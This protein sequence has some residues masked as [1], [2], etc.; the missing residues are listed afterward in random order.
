MI[1]SCTA[2][3]S[4]DE[5]RLG[6]V[7]PIFSSL[8][9]NQQFF[10]D[11]DLNGII[12]R[13]VPSVDVPLHYIQILPPALSAKVGD[14]GLLGFVDDLGN[15]D[16]AIA[17]ELDIILRSKEISSPFT[18]LE[19]AAF[20]KNRSKQ[21]IA[22]ADAKKILGTSKRT[23]EWADREKKTFQSVIDMGA[24]VTA[25]PDTKNN[26][27]KRTLRN[28]ELDFG[29][30]EW[31]DN[32]FRLWGQNF[33]RKK[34]IG[35]ANLRFDTIGYNN[36]HALDIFLLISQSR[37]PERDLDR[38][39]K[40]IEASDF[41]E[42]KWG[43]A[44]DRVYWQL[45]LR[46]S[47]ILEIGYKKIVETQNPQ[48]VER[49]WIRV[50]SLIFRSRKY[51]PEILKLAVEFVKSSNNINNLIAREVFIPLSNDERFFKQVA[52]EIIDWTHN[53]VR[54]DNVWAMLFSQIYKFFPDDQ[55]TR[56]GIIWLENL[57][58]NLK[59]WAYI[60][61]QYES[62]IER[63]QH[64]S[65]ALNWLVRAR[66]DLH[67]WVDVFMELFDRRDSDISKNLIGLGIEWL[68]SYQG[69]QS[70]RNKV[71]QTIKYLEAME[72]R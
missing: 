1:F 65:L 58:G 56:L 4:F 38:L 52:K 30:D 16:I 2:V 7:V 59:A 6:F 66:K 47:E 72:G 41:T 11:L 62:K 44:F 24:G 35:I 29:S 37:L 71:R 67:E 27:L 3:A 60:W 45:Y 42:P 31:T 51:N 13:F 53:N 33:E 18:R 54:S 21:R 22:L 69:N 43:Q 20:L 36:Q 61:R 25:E 48:K 17:Q 46:R 49:N 15:L 9:S 28:L 57:G 23:V 12:L 10:Q 14:N 39:L 8:D 34:L 50:W 68:S 40:S 64:N 19:V 5:S 32:W 26:E 55:T 70:N 63:S